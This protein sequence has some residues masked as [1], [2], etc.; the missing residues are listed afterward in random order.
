MTTNDGIEKEKILRKQCLEFA[1]DF[2]RS[3]R[4]DCTR[5]SQIHLIETANLFYRFV[6]AGELPDD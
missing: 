1:Y 4:M 6:V 2:L 5:I 3:E